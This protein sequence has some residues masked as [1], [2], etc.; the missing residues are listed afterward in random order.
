MNLL[1]KNV[2][3]R[4]ILLITTIFRPA[5]AVN[6][7][8]AC[9]YNSMANCLSRYYVSSTRIFA[10]KLYVKQVIKSKQN[11]NVRCNNKKYRIFY[12]DVRT[13]K[14]TKKSIIIC[15]KKIVY[16]CCKT[17]ND[18]RYRVLDK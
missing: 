16:N 17:I 8:C 1:N 5:N 14:M 18:L 3:F 7:I 2:F 4:A 12:F 9:A 6:V 15:E 10:C 13:N 11:N